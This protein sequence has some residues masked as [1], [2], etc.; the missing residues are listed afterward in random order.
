VTDRQIHDQAI[1]ILDG[2]AGLIDKTV[3]DLNPSLPQAR[4]LALLE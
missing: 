1:G 3:L 4:H 2:P